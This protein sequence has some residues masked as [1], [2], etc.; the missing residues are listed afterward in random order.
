[1]GWSDFHRRRAVMDRVL[2]EARREGRIPFDLPSDL[3][4]EVRDVFGTEERLLQAL[5]H[6]W[7]QVLAGHL[8]A[9]GVEP[10]QA[11]TADEHADGVDAVSRAWRAAVRRHPTLHAVVTASVARHPSLRRAHEEQ[12]RLLA[13]LSGLAEPHEPHD[14][15]VA[16]GATVVALF[17]RRE[18]ERSERRPAASP[19][20]QLLRR[21]A[22]TA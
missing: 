18:A 5:H 4:A 6:R 8:R 20:G 19:L 15:L 22:P 13:L 10:E 12:L 11:E 14:E 2:A 17:G 9:E 16:V 3:V 21:L 1:M 7:S